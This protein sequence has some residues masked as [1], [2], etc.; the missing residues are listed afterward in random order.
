[1]WKHLEGLAHV[2]HF[3]YVLAKWMNWM[4]EQMNQ[5]YSLFCSCP[6]SVSI[7]CRGPDPVDPEKL[8]V[9]TASDSQETTAWLNIN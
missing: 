6:V 7:H 4:R 1:M 8:K 5:Q 9:G 3:W 2:R